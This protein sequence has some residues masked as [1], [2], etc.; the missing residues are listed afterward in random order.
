MRSAAGAEPRSGCPV[1]ISLELLG[2]RWSLLIIRDL[3]VRACRTFHEFQN[4]GEGIA[5]NILSSRLR[6]LKAAGLVTTEPLPEDRRSLAYRLTE[7]GIALAPL[8]LELL[9]WGANNNESAA[10]A[11]FIAARVPGWLGTPEPVD[12][13]SCRLRA[14]V[15]D[16]VEWLAFRLA[17][18]D[19]DFTVRQPPELVRYVRELGARLTRAAGDAD[20]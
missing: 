15:G 5:S 18:V 3:M 10:P 16:S 6:R 13:H 8:L 4:A 1:S 7:K 2:D 11:E 20:R 17:V 9:I 14:S 19:C 12:E